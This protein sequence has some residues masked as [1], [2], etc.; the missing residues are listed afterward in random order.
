[1]TLSFI[2]EL[3]NKMVNLNEDKLEELFLDKFNNFLTI[4]R[5]AEY[6]N[7]TRY[8]ASRII[9]LGRAVNLKRSEVNNVKSK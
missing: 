6:Y 3:D 4:D 1:M 7:F 5:F 9:D 8:E 2:R